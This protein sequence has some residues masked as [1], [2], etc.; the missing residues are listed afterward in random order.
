[1]KS[2]YSAYMAGLMDTD[3]TFGIYGLRASDGHLNYICRVSLTNVNK[4][5]MDW[6]VDTFGG[7]YSIQLDYGKHRLAYSWRTQNAGHTKKFIESIL[8]YLMIKRDEA[9]I[10]LEYIALEGARCPDTRK[11]LSERLKSLK[12]NRE[13]VTTDMPGIFDG[14]E[15]NDIQAYCAGVL[16]GDG[17]IS[18]KDKEYGK[19]VISIT[20][21]FKPML[22]G[23]S[24]LYGGYIQEHKADKRAWL[25][26]RLH[27]NEKKEMFLLATLP[28]LIVKR[29]KA[30]RALN[31][32]RK[33]RFKKMKIQSD[34]MG[35]H[36]SALT[37]TLEAI[38][39]M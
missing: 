34:L 17:H 38:N 36:E 26:W 9:K 31:T 8:P 13:F 6:I 2:A 30:L 12:I 28:Y 22:T 37:G 3:G 18:V 20:N 21:K 33:S 4:S 25:E 7:T 19:T 32:I 29:E 35:D 15:K 24:L 27:N 39:T 5:L 1:M 14:W 23:I 11:Q 16:D 10:V